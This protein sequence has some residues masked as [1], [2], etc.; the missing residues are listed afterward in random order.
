MKNAH[1]KGRKRF[2]ADFDDMKEETKRAPLSLHGL[3]IKRFRAGDDEGAIEVAVEEIMSSKVLNINLLVSDTSEY[4]KSHSFFSYCTDDAPSNIQDAL[5]DM[6]SAPSRPIREALEHLLSA[7]AGKPVPVDVDMNGSDNDDD[8]DDDSVDEQFAMG[9]FE[10]YNATSTISSLDRGKMQRDFIDVVATGYRPGILKFGADDFCLS[11]SVP[12]ITLSDSIPPQALMAWDRR[13]LSRSQHL[14]LLI[15]GLRGIYPAISSDG[16]YTPAAKNASVQLKFQVGLSGR[17]KPSELNAKEAVRK[18]GLVLQDAEDELRIQEEKAAAAAAF[19]E[20]DPD[21]EEDPT[22]IV[23][24][25]FTAA[26]EDEDDGRFDKF[27]LS[28]SFESLLDQ[29]FLKV[30]QLRRKFGLGWAGAEVLHAQ[31]EQSQMAPTDVY[32]A[33]SQSILAADKEEQKLDRNLPHDPLHNLGK[34]EP[35]NLPLT[36]FAYLIRRITLCTRYCVVCH[37]KLSTEYEAL[38]PYVCDSKLCAYQYY[39]HNRG[40]S[41]EYEIIHN[42]QTVDLLVSLTYSAAAEGVLDEPF[43]VGMGLRVPVPDKSSLVGPPALR[44]APGAPPVDDTDT[45]PRRE[46]VPDN[47][48]LVDFDDLS[49]IQMRA[50]I[51][52]M[53]NC[54]PS[55][56]DMKKHLERKVKPGKSKPK[57]KEVDPAVPPAAW[58]ILRW[59]VG[60]CTAYLEPMAPDERIL[61]L[62]ASWKQFR[63]SV[64]APDMEAKFKSAVSMSQKKSKNAVSYPSL[65]AFHGSPLRNWHSIIRHG[66]WY[67]TVANGRAYGNGVYMAKDATVSM[68]HYSQ[69]NSTVWRKSKLG[70]NSCTAVVEAVNL[71]DDFV[72][73]D[74][75]LVVADT[76]WL[77]C[78]YLLVRCPSFVETPPTKSNAPQ[79]PFVKLDPKHPT[80]YGSNKI[81]IPQPGYKINMTLSER[82]R[83]LVDEPPDG[84]DQ[85]IFEYVE[86]AGTK[87]NAIEID[88]DDGFYYDDSVMIVEQ[89]KGKGKATAPPPTASSSKAQKTKPANDWKHDPEWVR[90]AIERRMPPPSESTPSS[91]MAVQR[92]LKAMLKE[93]DNASSL[94]ELGWYLPPDFID[95]NIFSWIVEMHSFDENIPIAKDMKAQR[96]NSIIFEIRFPAGYPLEPP[97]FRILTPRFLPF[98]HGGGGHVTGGGSICMD[99]LTSDGW[100]P[101]Y[102]MPAIIMQIKLAIS[103]LEPRPARL[104]K[105]WNRDYSVQEALAGF[106]RAAQT[107]GWSVP[108][109]IDRLV[110]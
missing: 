104:A 71:P 3:C 80:V 52:S 11:V 47:H 19:A 73:H 44:P 83:E 106:K 59:C 103:N 54:L 2:N 95:D 49:S 40:P 48:G 68:G 56:E 88:D 30:V 27:S 6:A 90:G 46:P 38:K 1:L 92:E 39:A 65:Y 100:L 102:S 99:L 28:S 110:R 13:L 25:T 57:L 107:H 109:G 21:A 86:K 77:L 91:T 41:L 85:D 74:P 63:F 70:P 96:V 26:E 34:S 61:G 42:P 62:D 53:I 15:S 12:V 93:Q 84:P 50:S 33:F 55:V 45:A 98:I 17:Y 82:R 20:W 8:D 64:G 9:D 4:P 43:P 51:A 72:S 75:Y 79:I 60:S 24:P 31:A 16:V 58:Q 10:D 32:N 97:F 29:N 105:D 35:I 81:Q 66:L 23:P 22:M 101:S 87:E 7:F 18:Y 5:N 89:T 78:R 69:G 108:L 14:V 36:A 37:N 76:T 67:K 94:K